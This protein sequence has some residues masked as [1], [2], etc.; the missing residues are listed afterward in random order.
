MKKILS[1]L[2]IVA[3]MMTMLF[4][5]ASCG[6][7]KKTDDTDKTQEGAAFEEGATTENNEDLKEGA[8]ATVT[9]LPEILKDIEIYAAEQVDNTSWTFSGGTADGVQFEME[10]AEAI[11]NAAGGKYEVNFLEAGS[12]NLVQGETVYE[13]TYEYINEGT[14]VLADF[15][16]IQMMCVFTAIDGEPVLIVVDTANSTQALYFTVNE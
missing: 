10:Q 14:A 7:E 13:G 8:D 16:G 3:M 2:L 6:E 9:E 15:D 4:T 12:I 11:L 1:M 5:A